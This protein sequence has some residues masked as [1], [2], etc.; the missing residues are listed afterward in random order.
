[1]KIVF[2]GG[3]TGGHFYPIIAIAEKIREIEH[4]KR[5][6]HPNLHF[7]A[8]DP[9]D[10]R[11]L[12]ENDITFEKIPAGKRRTYTSIKNVLDIFT[13]ASGIA[14]AF[15][16]LFNLYP[17]IIFAKGGYASFPTLC[18]ARLLQIPVVIHESDTVP[19]RV[20]KWASTFAVRIAT[21]YPQAVTDFP[22]EKTAHTGHPIREGLLHPTEKG[23]YEFLELE[24]D[25]PVV[26][27]LGGSQGAAAINKAV[28]NAL[29]N[30]I[31]DFQIIHQ[32]GKEHIEKMKESVSVELA[33]NPYSHRYNPFGYL[34]ELAMRMT[35]GAADLV[36]SRAGST[37]FE[38]ATWEVPSLLIPLPVAHGDHQ[39][40][41]AFTYARTGAAEVIEQR[42]LTDDILASQIRKTLSDPRKQREMSQAAQEVATRD[43]A[44]TIAREIIN[45]VLEYEQ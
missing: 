6:L 25:V 9:Y 36:V 5:L 8:P 3:G 14:K 44:D 26:L 20:N 7:F 39:H 11:A 38:I 22:E 34:D 42:N 1:M 24:E 31:E 2:T 45:L 18:A 33:D 28:L 40:K 37:I 16:K 23:A 32:T 29:P 43:A 12:F 15:V 17:D 21:S 41:N 19:G 13:T 30:L 27:I 4:E 10:E 35:A